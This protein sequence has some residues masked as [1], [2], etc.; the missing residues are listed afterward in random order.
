MHTCAMWI[1]STE[2]QTVGSNHRE[3]YFV[4][5]NIQKTIPLYFSN[6]K[7]LSF[8]GNNQAET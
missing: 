4:L 5:L 2:L 7:I 8:F 3:A 6:N 1:Q